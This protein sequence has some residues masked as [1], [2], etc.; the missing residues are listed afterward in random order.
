MIFTGGKLR[1]LSPLSG[2]GVCN[3]MAGEGWEKGGRSVGEARQCP[4]F[5]HARGMKGGERVDEAW[6]KPGNARPSPMQGV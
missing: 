6:D 2:E 3:D 5:T 1:K 4:P